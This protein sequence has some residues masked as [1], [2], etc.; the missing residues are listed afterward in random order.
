METAA[1]ALKMDTLYVH[2]I[3]LPI[4]S[5]V[6]MPRESAFEVTASPATSVFNVAVPPVAVSAAALPKKQATKTMVATVV[7]FIC[8][9]D[10]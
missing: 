9:A 6:V 10:L 8:A 7:Y 5:S 2:V 3:V 4:A 1:S